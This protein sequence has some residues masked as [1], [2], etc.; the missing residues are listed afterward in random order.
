MRSIINPSRSA[1]DAGGRLGEL[2]GDVVLDRPGELPRREIENPEP[3]DPGFLSYRS[4]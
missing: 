2:A 1:I 4:F 3:R